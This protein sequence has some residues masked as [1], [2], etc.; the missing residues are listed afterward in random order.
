MPLK[1]HYDVL[2]VTQDAPDEVIA[3]AYKALARIYHPDK[4]GADP[5]AAEIMQ[6]INV[7][8][9]ILSDPHK[10][11]EHDLWLTQQERRSDRG[12][13]QNRRAAP[14]AQSADRQAKADKTR[15]E[16]TKWTSWAEKT[17]QDAKEAQARADKALVDLTKAKPEDRTKW[18]AWVAKTVQEAKVAKEKADQAAAKSA[19][20]VAAALEAVAEATSGK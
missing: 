5:V 9:K 13:A 10:R 4:T 17:A 1:T 6:N 14:T 12:S 15:A 19:D 18:E 20:A 8:Y 2:K 7:S 16:A 3:A 11:A